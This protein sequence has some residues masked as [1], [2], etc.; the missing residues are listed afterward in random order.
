MQKNTISLSLR[1]YGYHYNDRTLNFRIFSNVSLY[2]PNAKITPK[3]DRGQ[4]ATKF[5][6]KI[7]F[8]GNNVSVW[9]AS[10]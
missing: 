10:L 6:R 9:D 4:N 8:T 2:I 1:K 5:T 3:D 7:I